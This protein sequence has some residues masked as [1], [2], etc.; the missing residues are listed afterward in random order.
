MKMGGDTSSH[1]TIPIL[2]KPGVVLITVIPKPVLFLAVDVVWL[3]LWLSEQPTIFI[4]QFTSRN[5]S[6]TDFFV[7]ILKEIL[8]EITVN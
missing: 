7:Y 4:F 2:W 3:R 8:R 1:T 6:P 5:D